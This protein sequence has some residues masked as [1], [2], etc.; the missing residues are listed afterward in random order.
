[1]SSTYLKLPHKADKIRP[2]SDRRPTSRTIQS[3]PGFSL[4]PFPI[5]MSTLT[6]TGPQSEASK[7]HKTAKL[8]K[9]LGKITAAIDWSS[10]AI[11][12]KDKTIGG[13]VF[14]LSRLEW[15][16]KRIANNSLHTREN[17]SPKSLSP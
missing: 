9:V 1:M 7:N 16:V 15:S 14:S 13:M 8:T 11:R 6:Q 5:L 3:S 17:A 4:N 10:K 2:T 12:I